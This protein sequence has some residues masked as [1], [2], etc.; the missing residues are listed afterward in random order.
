V[1]GLTPEGGKRGSRWGRLQRRVDWKRRVEMLS[2]MDDSP[3]RNKA[4][5]KDLSFEI[6]FPLR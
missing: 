6:E 4:A 1:G 2:L 5:A 3:Q